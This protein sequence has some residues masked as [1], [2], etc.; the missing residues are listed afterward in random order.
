M[1]RD[2]KQ[3]YETYHSKPKAKKKRAKANKARR[4]LGLKKGDKR[5]A[6]HVT[7][8]GSKARPQSIKSNRSHGGKVG[9]KAK[10]AAGGRKSK[11]T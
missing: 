7:R 5:D 6:G 3:E 1:A 2:Y 9:N 10:K 8:N 4:D 11:R